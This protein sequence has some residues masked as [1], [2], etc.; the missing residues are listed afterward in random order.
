MLF[1]GKMWVSYAM[2]TIMGITLTLLENLNLDKR[3]DWDEIR[4]VWL[5]N[6]QRRLT[7]GRKT[8][9]VLVLL[10]L[11]N[12][13]SL[14]I[15]KQASKLL[16]PLD[17]RKQGK[18]WKQKRAHKTMHANTWFRWSLLTFGVLTGINA[19]TY[20]YLNPER[21]FCNVW[22]WMRCMKIWDPQENFKTGSL[23]LLVLSPWLG[24]GSWRMNKG[25]M[26]VQSSQSGPLSLWLTTL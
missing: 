16:E 8:R 21:V 13:E 1:R 2:M 26:V 24:L 23:F 15:L 12:E 9:T 7:T 19:H 20:A 22:R 3:R 11:V 14:E 17:L 6:V 18:D 25:F 5:L 10:S 4:D